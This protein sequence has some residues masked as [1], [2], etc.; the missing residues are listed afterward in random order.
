M[1]GFVRASVLA[2]NPEMFGSVPYSCS[3]GNCTFAASEGYYTSIR[4][5]SS[6]DDI[7]TK[8]ST[9]PWVKSI[10]GYENRMRS[11]VVQLESVQE[12]NPIRALS[13]V[14]RSDRLQ[15]LD[16]EF[17]SQDALDSYDFTRL[18]PNRPLQQT[19]I[20]DMSIIPHSRI[21]EA[22]DSA[23]RAMS[24][25]LA[26]FYMEDALSTGRWRPM[27]VRCNFQPSLDYLNA[28][29][30]RG[31]LEEE[32]VSSHALRLL[33]FD[34]LTP[35]PPYYYYSEVLPYGLSDGTI[36]SCDNATEPTG[37]R[38]FAMKHVDTSGQPV[39]WYYDPLCVAQISPG[40]VRG[41]VEDMEMLFLGKNISIRP[42]SIYNKTWNDMFLED[43]DR[44]R[45]TAEPE[46][47]LHVLMNSGK[48]TMT[49]IQRYADSLAAAMTS[50]LRT[51]T[52]TT[53]R[54][55]KPALGSAT[56]VK[57]CVRVR[58]AWIAY[59]L[60]LGGCSVVFLV[61]TLWRSTRENHDGS[62]ARLLKSSAV[63]LLA[64][65]AEEEG[66]LEGRAD[67]DSVMLDVAADKIRT[68][69]RLRDG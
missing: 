52:N 45:L 14:T 33:D 50:S 68:K 27:A 60:A 57:T 15:I 59:P 32:L 20:L 69:L 42:A 10:L 1:E 7:S 13:N 16:A 62:Q 67:L 56:E 40:T 12:S 51:N 8:I 65:E 18:D 6:C 19:Q 54:G 28:K 9:K 43:R 29:I 47:H 49:S 22:T 46:P 3:V 5:K 63:A 61:A 21:D 23:S 31:N 35:D 4:I 37:N 30:T 11:Y 38:T 48:P 2:P 34:K 66:L 41:W 44:Y 24:S 36:I 25:I 26:L 17:I 64:Y 55:N 53:F 58:W 39:T